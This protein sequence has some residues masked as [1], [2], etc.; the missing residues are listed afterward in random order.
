M[1]THGPLKVLPLWLLAGA[2]L[3]LPAS[4]TAAQD[5]TVFAT[6]S[7]DGDGTSIALVGAAVRPDGLGLK[8]VLGVQLSRLQYDSGDADMSRWGVTP[9]AGLNYLMPRGA[10]EGRVGYSFQ[11]DGVE[12]A[13]FLEGEGGES[14]I[15]SALQG[16]YWGRGPELQG[17]ASY[18]WGADYLWSQAQATVPLLPAGRGGISAGAEAVWQGQLETDGPG[19][20]YRSWSVGPVLRVSTGR[21]SNAVFSVGYKDSNILDDGTWYARVGLVRY[22]IGF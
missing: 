18:N 6:A 7:A 17:I 10:I 15:V 8:P 16:N 22:G 12:P 11:E 14:G 4:P 9:S 13:P 1:D 19:E 2:A 21:E 3:A 5:A 20:A